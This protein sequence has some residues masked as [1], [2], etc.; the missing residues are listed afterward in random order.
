MGNAHG[1]CSWAMPA[2]NA[3]GQCPRAMPTG[4]AHGHCPWAMPLGN[5]HGDPGPQFPKKACAIPNPNFR[6]ANSRTRPKMY[7]HFPHQPNLEITLRLAMT[8][9]RILPA[10]EPKTCPIVERLV[11]PNVL[12]GVLPT[13]HQIV[14]LALRRNLVAQIVAQVLAQVSGPALGNLGFIVGGAGARDKNGCVPSGAQRDP[15]LWCRRP[16]W[17]GGPEQDRK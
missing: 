14:C 15:M 17:T 5:A 11:R 13:R 1:Q 8:R 12:R 4:N 9:C 16:Q 2:G 3:H 6:T 7:H 10:S